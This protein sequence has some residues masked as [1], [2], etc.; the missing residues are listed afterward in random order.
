MRL[1]TQSGVGGGGGV[2]V[3]VVVDSSVGIATHYRLGGPG[4]ESRRGRDIPH[5]FRPAAAPTQPPI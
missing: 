1:V 4:I 3:V 5:L 2:V